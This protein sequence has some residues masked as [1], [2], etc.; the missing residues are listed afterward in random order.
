MAD[1]G[2]TGTPEDI[3]EDARNGFETFIDAVDELDYDDVKNADEDENFG[4]DE[5]DEK[6]FEA[7]FA[8]AGTTC[9]EEL[10][11]PTDIPTDI[12]TDLD[13]PSDL[14]ESPTS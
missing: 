9:A 2:D 8:Y 3:P 4:I 11:V 14:T 6:D 10:G 12:P 1:L 13:I 7:F 5:D